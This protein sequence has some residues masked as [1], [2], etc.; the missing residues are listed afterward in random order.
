MDISPKYID[1]HT[2]TIYS[3]GLLSPQ[4]LLE[5]AHKYGL[6]AISITDHNT[7][8]GYIPGLFEYAKSLDIE[9]VSGIEFS[10]VDEEKRKYHILGYFLDL[11]NQDLK[12]I[13]AQIKIDNNANIQ[14]IVDLMK[15]D[16]W[17]I[18]EKRLFDEKGT[19][20][21]AHIAREIIENQ[22]NNFKLKSL[23]NGHIPTEGELIEATMI[24]NMPY[25]VFND[26]R[27]L[28]TDAI[29]IIKAANGIA[30][31]AHPAFNI[32]RGDN[33]PDL[34]QRLKNW[35]VDGFEAI[36]I[37]FDKSNNDS[38]FECIDL[39]TKYALANNLVIT[40]GS[41]FHHADTKMMGNLIDLGFKNHNLK[42]PFKILE[43]LKKYKATN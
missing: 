7:I 2:H 23:F 37:Q 26:K 30:I 34:C 41:D 36:S 3:D 28:P 1:L 6:S 5:K 9:L 22:K 33:A 12:N 42:V 10:C 24:A 18:G 25:F 43:D 27:I 40:G 29:K 35:G 39:F 15:K 14:A 17:F 32:M 20:T 19:L 13:T 4:A 16:H 8:D 31:A 21:K 11:E 38:E